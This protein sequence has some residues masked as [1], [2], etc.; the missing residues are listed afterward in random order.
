MQ[1][2]AIAATLHGSTQPAGSA[3][4]IAQTLRAGTVQ[5]H[6]GTVVILG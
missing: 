3:T 6:A 1:V 4:Y 5:E 2:E